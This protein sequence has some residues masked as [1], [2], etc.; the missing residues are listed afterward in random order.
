[1]IHAEQPVVGVIR[2]RR[3]GKISHEIVVI[4]ELPLLCVLRL[5]VRVEFRRVAEH[6]IPPA[7]HDVYRIPRCHRVAVLDFVAD[8][9]EAERRRS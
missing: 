2:S 3:K 8:L 9:R 7:N 6:G 1:M 4:S 5:T